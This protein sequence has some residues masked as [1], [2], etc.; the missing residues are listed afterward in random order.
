MD[1]NQVHEMAE[2]WRRDFLRK[3]EQMLRV[4]LHLRYCAVVEDVRQRMSRTPTD[5]VCP[6]FRCFR[7]YDTGASLRQLRVLRS[8]SMA[9][10]CI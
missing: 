10:A 4:L 7:G 1:L 8:V 9:T 6:I 2:A 5:A 3:L